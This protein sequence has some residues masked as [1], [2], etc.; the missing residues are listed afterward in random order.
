MSNEHRC[1]RRVVVSG[2][3]RSERLGVGV[4]RYPRWVAEGRIDED[5]VRRWIE[6]YF[7]AWRSNDRAEI[8]ALFTPD[9]TYRPKPHSPPMTGRTAI[10]DAWLQAADEPGGRSSCVRRLCANGRPQS[11]LDGR[12]CTVGE[13]S[14][15]TRSCG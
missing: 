13:R 2:A 3:L 10:A 6:R 4:H 11:R 12:F 5:H 14:P 15:G 7:A 9:A 1:H 8:E